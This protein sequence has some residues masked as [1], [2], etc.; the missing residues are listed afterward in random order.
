[1][2]YK[3]IYSIGVLNYGLGNV[4]SVN[5]ALNYLEI[6]NSI[7]SDAKQIK[8]FD[9]LILPGVGN[10]GSGMKILKKNNFF[11]ELLNFAQKKPLLGICLGMQLMYEKSEEDFSC[12]GLSL[13]KGSVTS[14]KHSNE[15]PVPNIGWHR[16]NIIQ[17][18]NLSKNIEEQDTFYFVHSYVCKSAERK[19]VV[20]NL[21]YNENFDVL[22]EHNNLFG[23]QFHPEKSQK[24][25]MKI[26]KNF[27]NL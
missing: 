2:N 22:I 15:Y 11:E 12:P 14:L 27:S 3:N 24:S 5:N 21:N 13:I 8:K 20:A 16:I 18:K 1:M 17:N 9:K 19:S 26:L 25:G 6:K 7:V 4:S 10:F 23:T